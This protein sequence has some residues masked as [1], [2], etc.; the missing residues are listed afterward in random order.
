M[1]KNTGW[2]L[3][4]KFTDLILDI[5]YRVENNKIIGPSYSYYVYNNDITYNRFSATFG[6]TK[7][8]SNSV[9]FMFGAG[10]GR[11]E[12]LWGVDEYSN[13]NNLYIKSGWGNNYDAYYV[14]VEAE[15]GLLVKLSI[16]NVSIGLNSIFYNTNNSPYINHD[17]YFDYQIGIGL[18]F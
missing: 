7:R 1:L 18:T 16:F 9:Y 3:R 15:A 17:A 4:T 13:S 5:D 11:R 2:Y 10:Y 8:I 12:L 6:I 14:G